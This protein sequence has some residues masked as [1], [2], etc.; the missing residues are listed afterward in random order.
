MTKNATERNEGAHAPSKFTSSPLLQIILKMLGLILVDAFAIWFL[1]TL[2][3]D[4]VWLLF[5]VLGIITVGVNIILLNNKLS[6]LRWLSPGLALILLMVI[7]PLVFTVYTAFTNY[8]DGHLLTKQQSINLIEKQ[9]YLPE[10]AET[11]RW[12][13]FRSSSGD[14]LLW[15]ISDN[16]TT[17]LVQEGKEP[18]SG[19]ESISGVSE[20]DEEGIPKQIEGYQRLS[21][22]D[23]IRAISELGNK[24]FGI[25][26]HTFKIKSMDV[27]AQFQQKYTYR[28]DSDTFIDNETG[29]T[30]QPVEGT[31][32]AA[33]GS[34]LTPGFQI[35]IGWDN[36]HKLF[37]SPALSGPLMTIFAWTLIFAVLSVLLTFGLGLFLAVLFDGME[38]HKKKVLRSLLIIPYTI[39]GF[40]SI[41]IWV[42]LF[43]PHLGIIPLTLE[44]WIGWS[45]AWF[46]DPFW[47]RIG[48]LI[49]NLWLGYPYMMLVCS[50]ALQS[51]PHEILEAAK[52]DGANSWQCFWKISMPLLLMSVGPLLISSFAMNFNNFTVIYLY[53]EG[54]PTIPG[55]PTPAGYTDILISYTY[56]LA[57]ASGRGSDYG[58]ASAITIIIFVVVAA[59]TLFNFRFTHVW[60]EVSENV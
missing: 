22:A 38:I 49:V 30:Y 43:N 2:A 24:E 25:A 58:Y 60:E 1:Y 40:I 32:T 9:Q 55:T 52:V 51:I 10:G 50:G 11:Y 17:F 19:N 27:A 20:R 56:R 29:I 57:F 14:Y 13:A 34:T 42:G 31:F 53:N 12:T 33:D 37:S 59:I 39:P 18:L 21:R 23:A 5:S 28:S 6:P 16:G 7:Y 48:V 41:L 36:F 3:A 46:S 44:R 47:A 26:P 35:T 4:G 45:P 8:S 54:G 15:L